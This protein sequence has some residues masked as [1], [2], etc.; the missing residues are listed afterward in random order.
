M[1][2]CKCL[3]EK[4][5]GVPVVQLVRESS[6]RDSVGKARL[7]VAPSFGMDMACPHF[8]SYEWTSQW[9]S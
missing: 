4:G 7:S 8:T 3:M 6:H 9:L 2:S 5:R 1:K